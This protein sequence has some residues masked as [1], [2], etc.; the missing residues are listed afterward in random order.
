MMSQQCGNA[1]WFV[2]GVHCLKADRSAEAFADAMIGVL[3]GSTELGPIAKRASAVVGRDF[4][5]DTIIPR[6]D[7][8]LVRASSA[9]KRPGGTAA[10]AYRM[11][12]LAEKLTKVFVGE[13]VASG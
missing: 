7:G 8:A 5:L 4:H 6:I 9:A 2:S 3:T 13:M 10:E 12:L 1:E 11:A